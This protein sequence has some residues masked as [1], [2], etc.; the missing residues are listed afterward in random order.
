MFYGQYSGSIDNK[1]RVSLPRAIRD[2]LMTDD[3]VLSRGFDDA[4]FGYDRAYWEEVSGKLLS[5]P[6][7]DPDARTVRRNV[8]SNAFVA[9]IDEQGRLV[10]PAK[11]LPAARLEKLPG[12]IVIIG[13]GDHFEIWEQGN[14]ET[15]AKQLE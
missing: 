8:F 10:I 3:V 9:K 5:S 7:G 4:I 11:L 2:S 15:Y 12:Q 13:A 6:L 1:N 14:W